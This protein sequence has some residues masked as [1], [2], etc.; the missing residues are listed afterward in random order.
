MIGVVGV[1]GCLFGFSVHGSASLLSL[2]SALERLFLALLFIISGPCLSLTILDGRSFAGEIVLGGVGNSKETVRFN[3]PEEDVQGRAEDRPTQASV[4]LKIPSSIGRIFISVIY[5]NESP[6]HMYKRVSSSIS[7][8]QK[9][10]PLDAGYLYG[11]KRTDL[12][13]DDLSDDGYHYSLFLY[14]DKDPKIFFDCVS[15]EKRPMRCEMN[16]REKGLLIRTH[17]PYGKLELWER[18]KSETD[19]YIASHWVSGALN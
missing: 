16:A 12:V 10:H 14:P 4:D 11:L 1:K 6:L 8:L 18:I 3:F 13:R 17:L 9:R 7:L 5:A 19:N 2:S 15:V